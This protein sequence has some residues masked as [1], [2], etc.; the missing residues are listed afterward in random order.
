MAAPCYSA[1]RGLRVACPL[2]VSAKGIL[3]ETR[4]VADVK[5]FSKVDCT[6]CARAPAKVA[7]RS[8]ATISTPRRPPISTPSCVAV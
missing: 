6:F 3:A 1:S 4:Y 2:A 8:A 5:E 7:A